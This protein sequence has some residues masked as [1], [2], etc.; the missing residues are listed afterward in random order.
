M[1]TQLKPGKTFMLAVG[2]QHL[3][4][5]KLLSVGIAMVLLSALV[6]TIPMAVNSI[7][8]ST[9]FAFACLHHAFASLYL[10][11][12]LIRGISKH[13]WRFAKE[14]IQLYIPYL[15]MLLIS[16]Y[17][18]NRAIPVFA[19]STGWL[20]LYLVLQGCTLLGYVLYEYLPK[21][22]QHGLHF[23]TGSGFVLFAYLAVYVAP[24]YG[25]SVIALLFFGLS[26]HSFAPLLWL[27][28]QLL[29]LRKYYK[30]DKST[31]AYFTAG[32]FVSVAAAAMFTLYWVHIHQTINKEYSNNLLDE[33]DLPAW[34]RVSQQL[35]HHWI[36]EKA[37]KSPLVYS[38]ANPQGDWFFSTRVMNRSFDEVSKHDPLIVFASL[39]TQ[40][41]LLSNKEKIKILE[42]LYDGRHQAQERLWRG[43]HLQTEQVISHV[44]L[45]PEY[46]MAYTE[47]IIEVRNTNP[48]QGWRREEEAVYTF[49][50][51]EGS[52]VTSLSLWINGVEEK[53]YLTT[54]QKADTAYR[55]VVGVEARDPSV[56]HWQEGNTVSVRVFPVMPLGSRRVKVG[57]TSPLQLDGE[58]LVYHNIYF[59]G[60]IHGTADE[61]RRVN[62][63]NANTHLSN[64][65]RYTKP[66]D[67]LYEY[68]GSYEAAWQ[69]SVPAVPV[70]ESAFTFNNKSYRLKG[71]TKNYTPATFERIYLDLN[72]TWSKREVET[73]LALCKGKKVYAW[74]NKM[75]K[76]D[77]DNTQQVID[78]GLARNYSLFPLHAIKHRDQSLLITK[79]T[80]TSAHLA[81]I[82]ESKFYK[83][84]IASQEAST[85]VRT[86]CLN[87]EEL[88]PYLKSLKEFR[89][90][91]CDSGNLTYLASLLEKGKFSQ[92]AE[93]ESQLLI[94]AAQVIIEESTESN[95]HSTAPDHLYR[96]FAYNQIMKKAGSQAIQKD[97][98]DAALVSL[99]EQAYVVSP[100]SSLVVLETQEDYERFDIKKSANSLE[101]ASMK[102]TGAAPEPHEWALIA[103]VVLALLVFMYGNQARSVWPF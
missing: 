75:I 12:V 17:A 103:V 57:I 89:M 101:N 32:L 83:E 45:W 56:I 6:F 71:Y 5:Q 43:E 29:L 3:L 22:L 35:P 70:A 100:V 30:T 58:R 52:V 50:L 36:T 81:D 93:S 4:Q 90:M 67:G 78:E 7:D 92:P 73:I 95:T 79:G 13:K 55:T 25:I 34:V 42:T 33:E 59:N 2:V 24:M 61:V 97:F 102:S 8:D 38:V 91:H 63:G 20:S 87:S 60:P 88:S 51:P 31:L 1:N 39:F 84:L 26:I 64:A 19:L 49:H 23:L 15:V 98:T 68:T 80:P 96:L 21:P 41:N 69:V 14:Q 62:T 28:G 40:H 85:P 27:T 16:A 74:N 72:A 54:K 65:G 44:R 99:A 86:Y 66:K 94:D 76:L 11:A 53:G 48:R 37:L 47:K 82:K 18:L 46:R 77:A 10:L 9:Y